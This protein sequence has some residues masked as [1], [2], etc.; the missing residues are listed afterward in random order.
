MAEELN[1]YIPPVSDSTLLNK[2]YTKS[3]KDV[4]YLEGKAELEGTRAGAFG[5]PTR[6]PDQSSDILDELDDI[7]FSPEAEESYGLSQEEI[8]EKIKERKEQQKQLS[9]II[10]ERKKQEA[11]AWDY[12]PLRSGGSLENPALVN[13][14][15]DSKANTTPEPSGI[16]TKAYTPPPK[17]DMGEGN[18]GATLPLSAETAAKGSFPTAY[19]TA[20]PTTSTGTPNLDV[21]A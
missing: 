11:K 5:I 12:R 9:M 14:A 3:S 7:D 6:A 2:Y 21:R 8:E 17:I 10:R 4:S 20:Q 16:V 13:I 15:K 1:T 18:P 19:N